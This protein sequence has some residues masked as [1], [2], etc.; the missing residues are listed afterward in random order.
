MVG[1]DERYDIQGP[2]LEGPMES[3]RPLA[4]GVMVVVLFTVV[5][6]AEEGEGAALLLAGFDEGLAEV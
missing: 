5:V 4:P 3:G 2:E 1:V 6:P